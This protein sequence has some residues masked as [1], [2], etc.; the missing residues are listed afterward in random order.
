MT[1]ALPLPYEDE[2]LY[3]VICRYMNE[4]G[5]ETPSR[6]LQNLFGRTVRPSGDMLGDLSRFAE[7]TRTSWGLSAFQIAQRCTLLP[8]Y[9]SYAT[10]AR[11]VAAYAFIAGAKGT[12][13]SKLLGLQGTLVQ[14]ASTFRFCEQCAEYDIAQV[15]EAYWKRSHQLPGIFAC[16][17]HGT[18]LQ[19]SSVP[20]KSKS[21]KQWRPGHGVIVST[22]STCSNSANNWAR[23]SDLLEVM[24]RSTELLVNASP[25]SMPLTKEYY[26]ERAQDV[27]LVKPSGHIKMETIRAEMI[28]MYGQEYLDA[29]GLPVPSRPKEAWPFRMMK[30]DQISYQPLQHVLLGH[31]LDRYKRTTSAPRPLQRITC[32]NR[33]ASHEPSHIVDRVKVRELPDGSRVGYGHCS[34]CGLRFSYTRC[35]QGTFSPEVTRILTL[36]KDWCEAAKLL[37][38]NGMSRSAIAHRMNV[39]LTTVKRL[40]RNRVPS[41]SKVFRGRKG[42]VRQWRQQW[43]EI[44]ANATPGGH[45]VAKKLNEHLYY[46]LNTYDRN[47][48]RK[49]ATRC[50]RMRLISAGPG[51]NWILRD[52]QWSVELRKAAARILSAGPKLI[53]VS[54]TA[55]SV[56]A[57][58]HLTPRSAV[59]KLPRCQAALTELEESVEHFQLRRLEQ[60]AH[61][62]ASNGRSVSRWRLLHD[63]GIQPSQVTPKLAA[64][65][66]RLEKLVL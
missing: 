6:T 23:N 34:S 26:Y 17:L 41:K 46:L 57:G 38:Q 28:G 16:L 21:L 45:K 11:R 50:A 3:S 66:E 61:G 60:V 51:V 19:I 44:L 58:L 5:V 39:S 49:S 52:K 20:Q 29:I 55:L 47:W 14:R 4:A 63:S 56:E 62:L 12:R 32:P 24:R 43:Q 1:V 8:Y 54:R 42:E 15:G 2:L 30:R 27:G 53:R 7:Q 18:A 10:E 40:L 36:G 25:A 37:R 48:L 9:T 33:Y 31:F 13:P 35:R 59:A 22:V 64:T 65:I